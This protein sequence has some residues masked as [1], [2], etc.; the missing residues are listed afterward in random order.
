MFRLKKIL[1]IIVLS[2]AANQGCGNGEATDEGSNGVEIDS[3]N[4]IPVQTHVIQQGEVVDLVRATGTLFPL[5]DVTISSQTA[6]T[7]TEV[8]VEVGARVE[9][10]TPLVQ[11][12][13]ELKQLALEQAEANLM[14]AKAA[15]DKAT[16]DFERNEKLHL[17]NDIS[18]YIFETARLQNKSA[19][20]TYL[21]ANA[22]VKMAKRQLTD[23][24]IVSPV[25]GL[26]AA[27]LV[28]L[29]STVATG[30]PIAK[31][32]DISQVKVKFG[33]A[34]K[35]VVKVEKG[36]PAT[37]SVDS[38]EQLKFSGQVSSVGPQANLST[39]TFPI[40]VL[41]DNPELQLKAGMISRVEIATQTNE[42]ALLLPKS[43]LLERA[44]QTIIYIIKDETARKRIPKLGIESGDYITILAGAEAGDEVVVIGQENLSEGVEVKRN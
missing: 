43:A 41:V 3:P 14:Q 18:Q 33:V 15:F 25:S 20:A 8:Y 24:R 13:P 39:R 19:E 38:Y 22:N 31:V 27:R 1:I 32:V 21:A 2:I 44:G 4:R 28:E 17:T 34:E 11:I 35:D 36:Q 37:I 16:K 12:D 40:E 6:G 5:H 23:A 7:V 10:G 42:E 9:K 29:G 30:V 26:V